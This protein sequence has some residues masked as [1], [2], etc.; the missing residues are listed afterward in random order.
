[1]EFLQLLIFFILILLF[2]NMLENLNRLK[3]TEKLRMEGSFPLV[4]VLIPARNE[5]RNIKRCLESLVKQEYRNLE[6]LVLDDNSTDGTFLAAEEVARGKNQVQIF[7]SLRLPPGWNGKNWACHQLSQRARGEWLLF[8]DADTVHE[9][10][11]VYKAYAA[12]QKNASVFISCIPGLIAQ[13]WAEKLY[14]PIIHFAFL[15]LVPF[16]LA[17]YS[18]NSNIPLGLGPFMFINKDFYQA[19]GGYEAIKKEIVDDIALARTVKKKGG[20]ISI[21]D[22][23]KFMKVRF[24]TS[25]KE[26]WSGF[27]KNSYEAIGASPHYVVALFILCYFL[28]IYPYLTLWG[29]FESHQNYS[30]PLSQVLILSLMKLILAVRFNTSIIYGLLHPFSV[31][32]ALLIL[33]NSLRLSLFKKKFEWKERLYP[34]E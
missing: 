21:L 4:S 25:F 9:P 20:K 14:M 28:F 29:A 23:S 24:Y 31:V 7:K 19:C 33:F 30:L 15:V 10:H 6:I 3:D 1:M 16:K 11:S 34:I 26:V 8:T 13:T 2:L 18:R 12:A 5:E 22:G 17:S 32:F 27:S